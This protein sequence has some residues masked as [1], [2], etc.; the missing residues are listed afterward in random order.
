[1]IK[2][3]K[4]EIKKDD[5]KSLSLVRVTL[6]FRGQVDQIDGFGVLFP[7]KENFFSLGV[8]ANSKIFENRGE[9][10][11][12]WILG[13]S[14]L[15]NLMSL[16][17]TQ[18]VE[19]IKQ[20]RW[21]VFRSAVDVN[22]VVIHRWANVVPSYDDVLR[23]F[24]DENKELTSHLSG[25]YLGVLGLTGILERNSQLVINYMERNKK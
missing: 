23:R 8:L 9:Y 2:L 18:I 3:D 21:R 24:L 25:N 15:P 16:S 6:N 4:K 12:S 14:V 1:M 17:D 13:D 10:N 7:N 5:F 20:D 11:E 19:K 22:D